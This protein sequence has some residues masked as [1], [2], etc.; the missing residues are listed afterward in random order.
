MM[1]GRR[2]EE[3]DGLG[4]CG[5]RRR[6]SF[7]CLLAEEG[8]DDGVA[9]KICW[10]IGERMDVGRW[11]ARIVS[12]DAER[13]TMLRVEH[14]AMGRFPHG[15]AKLISAVLTSR[16]MHRKKHPCSTKRKMMA[17]LL[18]PHRC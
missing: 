1:G 8:L 13:K 6:E 7:R 12:E 18:A 5:G 9:V 15:V 17:F 10:S 4:R 2:R 14:I 16:V 3:A 11:S